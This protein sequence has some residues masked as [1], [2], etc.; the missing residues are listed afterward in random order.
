MKL[1]VST[2]L[3]IPLFALSAASFAASQPETCA[4]K[5]QEIKTQLDYAHQHNNKDQISG[6]EKALSENKAHCTE[7]SLKAEKEHHVSEKQKKVQEREQ[8]LKEA[9]ATG[10][11]EKIAK[12]QKKLDEAQS[13]LKEAQDK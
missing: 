2:L 10:D 9:Q 7:A 3:A 4:S 5:Q 6:L 12:K 1:R 8:E 11:N 13:E